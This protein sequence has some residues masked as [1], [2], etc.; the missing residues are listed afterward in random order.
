MG[1]NNKRDKNNRQPRFAVHLDAIMKISLQDYL[2]L[3]NGFLY[4]ELYLASLQAK[5]VREGLTI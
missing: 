3:F 2:F 4:I 5:N 1:T